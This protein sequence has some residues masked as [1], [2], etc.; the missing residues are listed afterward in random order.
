MSELIAQKPLVA[1]VGIGLS[2]NKYTQEEV[3]NK[4]AICNSKVRSIFLNSGIKSRYLTLPPSDQTGKIKHELQQDLINKHINIGVE[5]GKKA[6][7][8]CLNRINASVKDVAY[9]CCVSSTGFISP[10]LSALLIKE[11][12]IPR[13]CARLD[14]VGMGCNGGLNALTAVNSWVKDNSDKLAVMVCVEVCSAVYIFDDSIGTS[15]VNSLFGDGA[16]ALAITGSKS[17]LI[18]NTSDVLPCVIRTSSHLILEEI[19]AMRFSWD[20]MHSKF[21]F[22]LSAEIPYVLGA[23]V[24]SALDTLLEG[25]GVSQLKIR[26]WIIHSGG[27][28]VIDSIRVNLCLTR[29][30]LRHTIS[31]LRDYGNV[32]SG[33]FLFSYNRLTQERVVESGDYGVMMTMGPGATIE[34]ALLYWR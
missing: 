25:T 22:Y 21:N 6:I 27:K 5:I 15:V 31:V 32:S 23:S 20:Q 17:Y 34:M 7:L 28:K 3:L 24:G 14:I 16:S 9:L 13:Q 12:G 29:Y 30:D 11:L 10:G 4:F 19:D 8:D 33:S 26:H 2:E 1:S 18:K